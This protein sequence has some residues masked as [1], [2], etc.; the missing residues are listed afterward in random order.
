M[1]AHA[2][3]V[4]LIQLS[5]NR[6]NEQIHQSINLFLGAVPVFGGKSIKGEVFHARL[7]S[8]F[9]SGAHSFNAMRMA[10]NALFAL[11][12]CPTTIT[13]HDDGHVTRC[14]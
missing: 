8:G 10:E 7:G 1:Q 6:M 3:F 5:D 14:S 11:I 4:Q 12:F 9:Q 2:I 13:I